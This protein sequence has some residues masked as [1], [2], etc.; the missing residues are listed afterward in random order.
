MTVGEVL[1]RATEHLGKTSETARLD[2]ELLLAHTLERE[3]IELYTEFD[4]P[5]ENGE[6]DGY[7]E[8]VVR[9]EG[10]GRQMRTSIHVLARFQGSARFAA[11]HDVRAMI[12]TG[13]Q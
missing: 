2:A 13:F 5:L 8:L 4:R 11:Q 10:C 1:R 6:L 7:R 3:R 12:R 9:R